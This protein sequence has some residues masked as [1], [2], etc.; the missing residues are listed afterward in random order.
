MKYLHNIVEEIEKANFQED[1]NMENVKNYEIIWN[2]IEKE[3][4]GLFKYFKEKNQLI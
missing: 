2:K 4:E 3:N 1:I